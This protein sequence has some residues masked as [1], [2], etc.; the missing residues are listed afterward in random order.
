MNE[1]VLNETDLVPRQWYDY[2]D[3]NISDFVMDM[4][5]NFAKNGYVSGN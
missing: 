1:T 2:E 3:R 5:T 4:F